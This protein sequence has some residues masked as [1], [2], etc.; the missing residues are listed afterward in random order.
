MARTKRKGNPVVPV[1]VQEVPKQRIYR[2]GGYV[3]L[4]MEDSG[5]PGSDTMEN[6]IALVRGYIE[7]RPDMEF[8]R[9]Y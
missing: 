3:R 9:L 6:Q 5:R 2:A 8:V 7:E 4:S 1:P